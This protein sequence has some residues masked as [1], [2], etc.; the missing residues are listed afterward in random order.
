VQ[1]CLCRINHSCR[2][3]HYDAWQTPDLCHSAASASHSRGSCVRGSGVF[4]N[5]STQADEPQ[6]LPGFVVLQRR[7]CLPL[8]AAQASVATLSQTL[9]TII[10]Q[11]AAAAVVVADCLCLC[12]T[13][14]SCSPYALDRSAVCISACLGSL[15]V[16]GWLDGA[17]RGHLALAGLE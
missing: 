2:S 11:A 8:L 15:S 6:Q 9:C 16:C 5:G 1:Y 12:C 13:W 17:Y 10:N 7:L 14:L 3:N 4:C